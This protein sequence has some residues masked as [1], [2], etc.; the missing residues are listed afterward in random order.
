MQGLDSQM[1]I[2]SSAFEILPPY[3]NAVHATGGTVEMNAVAI[4]CLDPDFPDTTSDAPYPFFLAAVFL[5]GSNGTLVNSSMPYI[6][7]SWL[8]ISCLS[9]LLSFVSLF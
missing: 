8:L 1:R 6:F 3:S 5:Q 9:P 7:I 2:D 4:T